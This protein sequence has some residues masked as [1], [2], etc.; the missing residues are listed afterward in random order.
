MVFNVIN[1]DHNRKEFIYYDIIPYFENQYNKLPKSKR[2]KT[3]EEWKEF[4]TIEGKS[5]FWSRCQYE[6]IISD[7]PSENTSKKIDVWEQIEMNLELIIDL[8]IDSIL[9]KFE[10]K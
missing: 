1:Y 4:V 2:P 8:I 3:K 10:T 5:Q 6:I 7:W 9:H